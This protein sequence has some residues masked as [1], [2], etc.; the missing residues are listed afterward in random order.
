M[1]LL[2]LPIRFSCSELVKL[3]N[4]LVSLLSEFLALAFFFIAYFNVPKILERATLSKAVSCCAVHFNQM[5]VHI[6]PLTE[7][8]EALTTHPLSLS[9]ACEWE[10]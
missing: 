4:K 8:N 9:A 1:A 6:L 10:V 2:D 7:S 5:L 3:L